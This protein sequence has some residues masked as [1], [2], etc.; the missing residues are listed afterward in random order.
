M[1]ETIANNLRTGIILINSVTDEQYQD[2]SVAPYH[3]SIGS[4]VRH[5]LDIFN[6]I[7]EGMA[8]RH[9]NLAARQRNR[10]IEYDRHA[11][12]TYLEHILNQIVGIEGIDFEQII[13][14]TDDLGAGEVTNRYTLSALLI[15]AHS[16]AIHHFA[17]MGY[18]LNQLG[19]TPPCAGFGY[20][21]TTP[22]Q[23]RP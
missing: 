13:S 23:I 18:V 6:C 11:A 10:N 21:P 9:V 17:A 20:N 22:D 14:V 15:Q 19:L 8:D 3:S 1:L 12:L 4:H 2:S 7:F 16:H 5:V